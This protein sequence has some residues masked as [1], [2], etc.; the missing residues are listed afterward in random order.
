MFDL[1]AGRDTYASNM[2]RSSWGGH[3]S[4]TP[5][6]SANAGG[7]HFSLSTSAEEN[8]ITVKA[9]GFGR[10]SVTPGA[11]FAPTLIDWEKQQP[12]N[13][14]MPGS[15]IS[16]ATLFGPNGMMNLRPVELIVLVKPTITAHLSQSTY[17]QVINTLNAGGGVSFGPFSFG[18]SYSKT[19]E[20][21]TKDDQSGTIT[22][23]NAS[24]TPYIIAVISQKVNYVGP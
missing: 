5:F 16:N 3:A 10:V 9:R 23:T 4:Y 2:E 18:G 6:F 21:V 1:D 24:D 12:G 22:I 17:S 15:T 13:P 19:T 7:S 11:W 20:T 8:S 14:F